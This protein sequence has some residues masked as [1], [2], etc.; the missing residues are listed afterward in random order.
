[1]LKNTT[2]LLKKVKQIILNTKP[3][4]PDL[5]ETFNWFFPDSYHSFPSNSVVICP[6][7]LCHPVN[8]QTNKTKTKGKHQRGSRAGGQGGGGG[9]GGGWQ[10]TGNSDWH[11]YQRCGGRILLTC[12]NYMLTFTTLHISPLCCI[13][14]FWPLGDIDLFPIQQ[15]R[16][17]LSSLG[18]GHWWKQVHHFQG[19]TLSLS[20]KR[21]MRSLSIS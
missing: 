21:S 2:S 1:M 6:G 8:W 10:H 11:L 4:D 20:E 12:P 3:P 5:Q 13:F 7:V 18:F 15:T 17:N 9:G 14:C 16:I 19:A